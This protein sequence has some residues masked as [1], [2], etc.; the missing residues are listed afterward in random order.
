MPNSFGPRFVPVSI[1]RG[2]LPTLIQNIYVTL[3]YYELGAYNIFRS[4]GKCLNRL[5]M[6]IGWV[7]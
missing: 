2:Y 4:H 3:S 5:A 6:T 1:L 7:E